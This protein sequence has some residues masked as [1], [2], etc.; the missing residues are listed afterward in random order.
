MLRNSNS[1]VPEFLPVESGNQKCVNLESWLSVE[2]GIQL[3]ESGMPLKI[4]IR[5]PSSTDKNPES[6]L[7]SPESVAWNRQ[8][9]SVLDPLS[10]NRT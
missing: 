2:S 3:K 6:S 1:G 9:K 8:S 5:N 10:D 7:W 4:G